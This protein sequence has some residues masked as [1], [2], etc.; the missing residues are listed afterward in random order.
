MLLLGWGTRAVPTGIA[1]AEL[2]A[3][4]LRPEGTTRSCHAS[5]SEGH[6]P[7]ALFCRDCGAG[8]P[9]Q[10]RDGPV[11]DGPEAGAVPLPGPP[12]KPRRR[13]RS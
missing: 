10:Q 2:T 4:R 1:S 7:F 8:L 9:V 12:A 6:S 11:S 13:C 5:L 3:Q